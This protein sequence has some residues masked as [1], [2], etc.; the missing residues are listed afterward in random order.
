[1][2]RDQAE[3]QIGGHSSRQSGH[4]QR[5]PRRSALDNPFATR[6]V[7]PGQIPYYFCNPD[8]FRRMIVRGDAASWT[9]QIVGPHGSGKTTLVRH[10]SSHL[11]KHFSAIEFFIVRG[12]GEVQACRSMGATADQ[13][14]PPPQPDGDPRKLY[15][16]DGIERLS[17]LQRLLLVA[18]CRRKQIGLLVTSHRRLRGLPVFYETSFDQERFEKILQHLGTEQYSDHYRRLANEF[19]DNCREM[20][21]DLYDAHLRPNET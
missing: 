19:G 6:H 10:L 16:L 11:Q 8:D 5:S 21:F 9:G 13:A 20:L 3:S 1:M 14:F 18:D 12:I 2:L 17:W 15:V 7:A 4:R